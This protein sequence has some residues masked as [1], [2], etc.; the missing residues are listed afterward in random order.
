M[1]GNVQ[2]ARPLWQWLLLL[3]CLSR[4]VLLLLELAGGLYV[5]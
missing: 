1:F 5:C 2:A 4:Y 3:L